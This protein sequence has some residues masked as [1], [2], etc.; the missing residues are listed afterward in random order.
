MGR[1]C[2]LGVGW[3]GGDWMGGGESMGWAGDR[4]CLVRMWIVDGMRYMG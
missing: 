3:V 4:R 1:V 2:G